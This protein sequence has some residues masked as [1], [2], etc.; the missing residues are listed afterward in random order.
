MPVLTQILYLSELRAHLP[1]IVAGLVAAGVQVIPEGERDPASG[2]ERRALGATAPRLPLGA[3]SYE[4]HQH[5]QHERVHGDARR[6]LPPLGRV[7]LLAGR[8][9]GRQSLAVATGVYLRV[10]GVD[11]AAHIERVLGAQ[12]YT[13]ARHPGPPVRSADGQREVIS[14]RLEGV[15]PVVSGVLVKVLPPVLQAQLPVLREVEARA[16]RRA[17]TGDTLV[18]GLCAVAEAA[19]P[20]EGAELAGLVV[21]A[22][23]L[24]SEGVQGLLTHPEREVR[25]VA[26]RALGAL[27]EAV[28]S[29]TTEVASDWRAPLDA[30]L[31]GRPHDLNDLFKAGQVLAGAPLGAQALQAVTGKSSTTLNAWHALSAV[32]TALAATTSPT[33]AD[34]LGEAAHH[35]LGLCPAQLTPEGLYATRRPADRILGLEGPG[36]YGP[37]V[38]TQ[39]DPVLIARAA[40]GAAPG[41]GPAFAELLQRAHGEAHLVVLGLVAFS[42]LAWRAAGATPEAVQQRAVAVLTELARHWA[43]AHPT[44]AA[45]TRDAASPP[46]AQAA[47][48]PVRVPL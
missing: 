39:L 8:S 31:R 43:A 11:Q 14:R 1:E 48:A 15:G 13:V 5:E 42:R 47:G 30:A 12:G 34:G 41:L 32:R 33:V 36:A 10:E 40:R 2:G 18:E 3:Q 20:E 23:N 37:N 45:A 7:V 4:I 25:L 38:L 35:L 22:Q 21:R 24:T 19:T 27:R 16:R 26:V 6:S 9:R 17:R 46:A 44:Q 28:R 29:Q